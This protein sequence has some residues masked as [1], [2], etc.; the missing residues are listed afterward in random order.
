MIGF[1]PELP[2]VQWGVVIGASLVAAVTDAGSRRIPNVLTM[3][4]LLGGLVWALVMSGG[5]GLASSLAAVIILALPYVLLFVFAGGGAGDAKLMGALGAWL[6]LA[7]GVIVL[8]VVA[9]TGVVFAIGWAIS[10]KKG[11]EVMSN[12]SLILMALMT[13]VVAK[14]GIGIALRE[15]PTTSDMDT[16]PYGVAIFIGVC[17]AAGGMLLWNGML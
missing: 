2:L 11:K 10:R 1:N 7:Q 12:M 6:G 13:A 8:G 16:V 17:I 15:A 3:P 9:M 5:M 14:S 4:V